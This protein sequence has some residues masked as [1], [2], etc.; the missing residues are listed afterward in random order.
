MIFFYFKDTKK[1]SI[2]TLY[3]VDLNST[4]PLDLIQHIDSVESK[5]KSTSPPPKKTQVLVKVTQLTQDKNVVIVLPSSSKKQ[6]QDQKVFTLRRQKTI[7]H[8][9]ISQLNHKRIS[10]LRMRNIYKPMSIR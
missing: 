9:R 7:H 3:P 1:S 4:D 6:Y 2:I 8:L 10:S 5:K